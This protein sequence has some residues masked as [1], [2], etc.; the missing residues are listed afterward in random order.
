MVLRV[1]WVWWQTEESGFPHP[2]MSSSSL[3]Q[4]LSKIDVEHLNN[5][6]TGSSNRLA[7]VGKNISSIMNKLMELGNIPMKSIFLSQVK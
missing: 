1:T 7:M 2:P 3:G 4:A 6:N 5:F